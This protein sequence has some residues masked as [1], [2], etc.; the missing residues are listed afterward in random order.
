MSA[1]IIRFPSTE[2]DRVQCRERIWRKSLDDFCKVARDLGYKHVNKEESG[3]ID[4]LRNTRR[5][6]QVLIIKNAVAVREA[7]AKPGFE[8]P[9]LS[10]RD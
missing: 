3:L 7:M 8:L 9:P 1:T 10:K 5:D 6:G 4:L 2:K